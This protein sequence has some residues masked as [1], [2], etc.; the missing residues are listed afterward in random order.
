VIPP[1]PGALPARGLA[2]LA[3]ITLFWGINWPMMK[4]GL[5][6]LGPWSFAALRLAVGA[7][8]L[9]ACALAFGQRLAIPA[10]DRR[11]LLVVSLLGTTL[12]HVLSSFGISLM[13][14]GRAA[15]IAFTMP[16]WATLL[17]A[18]LLGERIGRAQLAG[19]ALGLGGLALLL[20]GEW[21]VIG[22][23][24]AGALFMLGA[25]L[26][27]GAASVAIKRHPWTLGSWPLTAWQVLIGGL[28]VMIAAPLLEGGGRSAA[29]FAGA[30]P[31]A[32]AALAYCATVP[33]VF[34][35]WGWVRLLQIFPASRAAVGTLAI[36]IVGVW[37]SALLLG[38]EIGPAELGALAAVVG[39]LALVLRP[40]ARPA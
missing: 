13:Q 33:M 38:E 18:A 19:L 40:R 23:A 27:W 37:S 8:G 1:S 29:F 7:A 28:P 36:P 5:G 25:A 39:A 26:A 14:P 15:I 9:F 12:W 35:Q 32:L 24:P 21:R 30:S 16:I 4:L 3:A 31:V 34:C 22:A 17:S 20:V 10:A 2:L 6:G 11:A